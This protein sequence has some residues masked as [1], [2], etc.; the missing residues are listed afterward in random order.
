DTGLPN[1]FLLWDKN[2]SNLKI[3]A[4]CSRNYV[5]YARC[6]AFPSP[7]GLAEE[8]DLDL[9]DSDDEFIPEGPTAPQVSVAERFD[10]VEMTAAQFAS[11]KAAERAK[12]RL[13]R[14]PGFEP[15]DRFIPQMH[16]F[17]I[18][19][20]TLEAAPS[21][22]AGFRVDKDQLYLRHDYLVLHNSGFEE[23]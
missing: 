21:R 13:F 15:V 1:M 19:D 7:P 18:K 6:Y 9:V 2:G 11:L 17:V 12:Y 23:S 8:G 16:S 5:K 10:T 4:Y 3:R 14:C 22:W 20:I